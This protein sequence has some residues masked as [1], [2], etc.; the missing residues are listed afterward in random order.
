V[1]C[2]PGR[3][4]RAA[5]GVPSDGIA[6][7]AARYADVIDIQAQRI[8]QATSEYASFVASAAAQARKA[9]P[10]VVV[11]AGLRSVRSITPGELSAAYSSVKSVVNGYWLNIPGP[12]P[13]CPTCQPVY[14]QPALELLKQIYG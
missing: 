10:H 1:P 8:E 11:L 14:P 6:A 9:N 7:D 5:Q 12:T 2:R 3:L 13:Q 4:R